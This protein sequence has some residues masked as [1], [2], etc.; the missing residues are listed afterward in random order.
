MSKDF[1]DLVYVFQNCNDLNE[2]MADAAVDVADY[3]RTEIGKYIDSAD[4]EEGVLCHMEGGY[5]GTD[6]AEIISKIKFSLNMEL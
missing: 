3:L 4:F 1:E 5:Y 2:Q 6:A